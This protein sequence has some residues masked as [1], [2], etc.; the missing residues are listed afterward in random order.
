LKY[1]KYVGGNAGNCGQG[2]QLNDWQC[3]TIESVGYPDWTSVSLG[4]HQGVPVIAYQDSDDQGNRILKVARPVPA[5]GV[6]NCG[7][8]Q[9]FFSWQCDVI[10]DGADDHDTGLFGR[11]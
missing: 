8:G 5:P 1:A 11:L 3:I 6:G 4:V 2:S 10:D 9:G 7:P